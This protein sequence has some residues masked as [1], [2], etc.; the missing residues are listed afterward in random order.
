MDRQVAPRN[1]WK[2]DDSDSESEEEQEET[3][4]ERVQENTKQLYKVTTDWTKWGWT[5]SKNCVYEIF[6]HGF[7]I[8]LP[9]VIFIWQQQLDEQK[10]DHVKKIARQ[11]HWIFCIIFFATHK[12]MKKKK[13]KML[14][15]FKKKEN[16]LLIEK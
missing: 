11:D 8:T 9:F 3:F 15:F 5:K 6:S 16:L 14:E 13:R 12:E 7:F 2:A 10:W 4:T 1:Y